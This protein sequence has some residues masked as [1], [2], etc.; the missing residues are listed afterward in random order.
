MRE[1]MRLGIVL[2]IIAAVAAAVLAY[3]NEITKGPIEQQ[4]LQANIEARKSILEDASDFEEIPRDQFEN[5]TGVSEVYR[6]VKDGETVGFTIKTNPEGY[7][8]PIEVTVGIR[9]DGTISGLSI[10]NH[11]ET[12]GL[13]A[14]ASEDP[15][16]NQYV[17]K[18]VA[19]EL[20]VIKSGTPKENEIQAISGATI[21]SNAVTTGVNTAIKLFNEKLNK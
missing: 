7:G 15:F 8:G 10:G 6:G 12:P 2:L 19:Q 1:V 21:T 16:K 9:M 20:S 3:T 13:G 4:V 18:N 11:S 14:K 5:Y 17:G